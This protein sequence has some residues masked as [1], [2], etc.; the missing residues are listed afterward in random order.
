[1]GKFI[2]TDIPQVEPPPVHVAAVLRFDQRSWASDA[3]PERD[4][5]SRWGVVTLINQRAKPAKFRLCN[6]LILL[7]LTL[8]VCVR[9]RL[10]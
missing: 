4:F 1:M 8:A 6:W 5:W 2:P 9:K 10:T 3:R 7:D